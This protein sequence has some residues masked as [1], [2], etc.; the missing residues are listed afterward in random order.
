MMAA[1]MEK[2]NQV[3]LVQPPRTIKSSLLKNFIQCFQSMQLS[4]NFFM[5]VRSFEAPTDSMVD[6]TGI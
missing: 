2:Y 5:Y 4:G 1:M 6:F 3:Q